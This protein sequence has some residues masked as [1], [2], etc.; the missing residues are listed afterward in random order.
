[1]HNADENDLTLLNLVIDEFLQFVGKVLA[2][3]PY[4]L[5]SFSKKN[6]ATLHSFLFMD[7]L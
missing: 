2:F 1:M 4:F 6:A 7:F 5:P 3:I